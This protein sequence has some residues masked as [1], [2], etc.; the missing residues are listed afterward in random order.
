[1]LSGAALAV[2]LYALARFHLIAVGALGPA[3]SSGLLVA[4]GLL[5]LAVALPFIVAQ[6]D[7]KRL[8]AYS[9][10]EHLGLATLAL[11]FGGRLALL[12]LA[13]GL[14]SH[15]LAKATVFLAAGRLVAERGSRRIG[16]LGGSLGR[17]PTEGRALLVAV[18]MLAG[19]PPSGTFAAEVAIV[20]G[21]MARGWWLAAAV[22]AALLALALAGLLFHAVRV[23]IGPARG[24]RVNGQVGQPVARRSL[25]A[26]ILVIPLVVVG[27]AGLW[28]PPPIAAALDQV[29]TAL[30]AGHD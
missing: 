18:L 27:L 5:S 10:I 19:L 26:M 14:V 29:V 1:M 22:A 9:S 7:L 20:F 30:G 24:R 28:T 4:L 15:G 8:L 6:G 12:G 11:G 3:F 2:S 16:R 17:S 25:G 13:L 23:S 21:G